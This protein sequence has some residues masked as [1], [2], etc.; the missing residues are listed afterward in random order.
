MKRII[1]VV[2]IIFLMTSAVFVYQT[3]FKAQHVAA[4][5]TQNSGIILAQDRKKPTKENNPW[6]AKVDDTTITLN[7]FE[8]EFQVHVYALPIDDIQKKKYQEDNNNK[9]KFLVNLINEYL[10]YKKA[11]KEN[12]DER[13]DVQDLLKAVTRRAIIQVYLNDKIE[14]KLTE[15]PDEQIE[16]I[17]NQ[18]KKLF[19]GVDIDVARQQIKM[20]LL[21]KQYNDHLNELIDSLKGEAKVIKNDDVNL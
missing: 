8:K 19:A 5:D 17:Y 14:P 6:L 4:D 7:D 9:K 13:S 11:L 21:Q 15:I 1:I 12:Y 16:A 10:I 3:L 18:N 2:A 20:Q